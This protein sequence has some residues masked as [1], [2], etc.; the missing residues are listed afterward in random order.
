MQLQSLI[1]EGDEECHDSVPVTLSVSCILPANKPPLQ[2]TIPQTLTWLMLGLPCFFFEVVSSPQREEN[3]LLLLLADLDIACV[4]LL[5]PD[6]PVRAATCQCH[7][8]SASE[9]QQ[10]QH[11]APSNWGV[12]GGKRQILWQHR[13][14]TAGTV[15]MLP[16]RCLLSAN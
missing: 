4:L 12:W 8:A 10:P 2:T 14:L 15:G 9:L 5:T 11:T 7:M 13:V 16:G 1:L 3:L 6:S